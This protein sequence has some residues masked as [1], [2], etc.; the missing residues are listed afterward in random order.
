[1]ILFYFD[2]RIRV[3]IMIYIYMKRKFLATI[4]NCKFTVVNQRGIIVDS[5]LRK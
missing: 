3:G 1:M 5:E 4:F 2:Q